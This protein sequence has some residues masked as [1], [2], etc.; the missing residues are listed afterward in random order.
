M[1]KHKHRNIRA[2]CMEDSGSKSFPNQVRILSS[3]QEMNLKQGL[4]KGKLGGAGCWVPQ[5]VKHPTWAQVMISQFMGLSPMSGSVFTAQSLEPISESVSS[6]LSAPPW[7]MLRL[8]QSLKNNF[9]FNVFILFLGQRETE[10]EW[11]RGRE[12]EREREREGDTE[13][14]AGS[15]L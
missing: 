11:G 2:T 15:R 4:E 14:E 10:H 1:H 8:S 6:S 12:R 5:S 9:F 3:E 13:S 7:L